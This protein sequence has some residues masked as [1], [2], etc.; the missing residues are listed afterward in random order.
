VLLFLLQFELTINKMGR[1]PVGSSPFLVAIGLFRS[2]IA[3]QGFPGASNSYAYSAKA[4]EI[5]FTTNSWAQKTK[6]GA[7][8]GEGDTV[9]CGWNMR[10]KT[11][12]FTKVKQPL[13]GSSSL[14]FFECLYVCSLCVV[15]TERQTHGCSG[16]V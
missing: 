10:R 2:G 16:C 14:F 8:Y 11:I 9:G 3:F 15:R 7:A 1:P 13:F 6:W 5:H 4:G 12:Y